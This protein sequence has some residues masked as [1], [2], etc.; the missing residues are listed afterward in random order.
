MHPTIDLEYPPPMDPTCEPNNDTTKTPSPPEVMSKDTNISSSK[1][2]L[3][4]SGPHL[5]TSGPTL[6][7]RPSYT[8]IARKGLPDERLDS[9]AGASP[10]AASS[11]SSR[12]REPHP[13]DSRSTAIPATVSSDHHATAPRRDISEFDVGR[14]AQS[15]ARSQVT[16]RVVLLFVILANDPPLQPPA[17]WSGPISTSP[18]QLTE[19]LHPVITHPPSRDVLPSHVLRDTGS[20]IPLDPPEPGER[21]EK[22]E[23]SLRQV[24]S[25]RERTM[26]KPHAEL[27]DRTTPVQPSVKA[28]ASPPPPFP[29]HERDT[30]RPH[31]E[32]VVRTASI[33]PTVD[34][35][36]PSPPPLKRPS[37]ST[38][39]LPSFPAPVLA[40]MAS[41]RMH[42]PRGT[43][44]YEHQL[45]SR[46]TPFESHP[47]SEDRG[48][49]RP[50][51]L[52]RND[53]SFGQRRLPASLPVGLDSTTEPSSADIPHRLD[54]HR[55]S[56]PSSSGPIMFDKRRGLAS[57]TRIIGGGGYE[58][59]TAQPSPLELNRPL[60]GGP[61]GRGDKAVWIGLESSSEVMAPWICEPPGGGRP[62]EQP[63]RRESI[64]LSPS[65]DEPSGGGGPPGGRSPV[66][67]GEHRTPRPLEKLERRGPQGG[68]RPEVPLQRSGPEGE[69][70]YDCWLCC[71]RCWSLC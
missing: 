70:T 39:P 51:E 67:P 10:A 33:Q 29:S 2:K 1:N 8:T 20:N 58:T 18:M 23:S 38:S 16:P 43:L 15:R 71:K 3:T 60:G 37:A 7:R 54:A 40:K 21:M 17:D 22:N 61:P 32:K 66:R 56:Y 25:P 48:K 13:A 9:A 19:Q 46:G 6:Q 50:D 44:P 26:I 31:A 63:E 65:G 53:F 68:N 4:D 12:R 45:S 47:P 36:T 24:D 11:P 41:S 35:S 5:A 52:G 27:V 49:G 30:I 64:R 14:E 42:T 34:P 62:P 69:D 55:P 57:S 59:I 28:S